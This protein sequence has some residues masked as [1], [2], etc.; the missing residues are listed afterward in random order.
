VILDDGGRQGLAPI[1]MTGAAQGTSPT[2]TERRAFPGLSTKSSVFAWVSAYP[3]IQ[4]RLT[5]AATFTDTVNLRN[6]T[7]TGG[8]SVDVPTWA[9]GCLITVS[10]SISALGAGIAYQLFSISSGSVFAGN[11]VFL[12]RIT[13]VG[14]GGIDQVIVPFFDEPVFNVAQQ[15]DLGNTNGQV[16]MFISLLGFVRNV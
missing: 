10:T 7:A 4:A 5:V 13:A 9:A 15:N 11:P 8:S 6:N 2:D 14:G 16:S 12:T 3:V 1:G